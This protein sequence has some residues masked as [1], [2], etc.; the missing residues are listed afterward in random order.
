MGSRGI[1]VPTPLKLTP[2]LPLYPPHHHHC[3]LYH[4]MIIFAFLVLLARHAFAQD[5]ILVDDQ[6]PRIQYGGGTGR[7]VSKA[8]SDSF[9][10]TAILTRSGGA[11]ASLLFNGTAISVYG[12]VD[13]P[14]D[15]STVSTYAINGGAPAVFRAPHVPTILTKVLLYSSPVLSPGEQNLTVTNLNDD[16]WFWFD[17]FNITVHQ[18]SIA[19]PN[20]S[21][22][23]PSIA[24]STGV[25]VSSKKGITVGVAIG[26]TL[27]V[28]CFLVIAIL[29][30]IW[31]RKHR[32]RIRNVSPLEDNYQDMATHRTGSVTSNRNDDMV[33]PFLVPAASTEGPHP[34]TLMSSLPPSSASE[35]PRNSVTSQVNTSYH[36]GSNEIDA[37][38][39]PPPY[40]AT[41]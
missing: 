30:Y 41:F 6:D 3:H 38:T 2:P 10:G 18:T 24:T 25:Q 40:H 35:R 12:R 11:T 21:S 8:K 7:W 23:Q 4:C 13:P 17:Y 19:N 20:P 14:D 31:L 22:V 32:S 27:G 33:H 29:C 9:N 16:A 15:N 26:I 28:I 34:K 37:S 36:N 5:F 1:Q 39:L